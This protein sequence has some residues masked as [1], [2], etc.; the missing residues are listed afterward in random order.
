VLLGVARLLAAFFSAGERLAVPRHVWRCRGRRSRRGAIRCACA[1]Q[2]ALCVYAGNSRHGT[3]RSP[4]FACIPSTSTPSRACSG[5]AV[6]YASGALLDPG[7]P[8]LLPCWLPLLIDPTSCPWFAWRG[9]K[10]IGKSEA[11]ILAPSRP[12]C[13]GRIHREGRV[14]APAL[15]VL[16]RRESGRRTDF[17]GQARRLSPAT[18]GWTGA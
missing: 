7:V 12:E 2:R 13:D 10:S 8:P 17:L 3:V 11:Q 1:Q 6:R 9:E 14:Q 15:G 4:L 18:G 5:L 16:G